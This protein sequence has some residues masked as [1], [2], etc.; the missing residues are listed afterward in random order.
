MPGSDFGF[1]GQ[2]YDAPNPYQDAQRLINWYLE[3]SSSGKPKMPTTLLG[4]PGLNPILQLKTGA[5]RG[6]WVLP[7]NEKAVVVSSDTVYLVT[8][9]VPAT[10]NSIAEFATRIIGTLST[11][12]GQVRMRDN[13]AGGYVSI[14]DGTST[15][16]YFRINGASTTTI[17]ATPTSGSATLPYSGT[18]NSALIVGSVLSG[19]GIAA[20]ATI[21]SINISA[22]SITMSAPATSS[23]G[24]TTVTVTLAEFGT[25]PLEAPASH[26]AFIDGWLIINRVG[27]QRFATSAPVPYT[28][29]FDPLF[30]ALKDSQSDNLQGLHELNRELWLIGERS[31]EIWFTAPAANFGFQRVPGASP[32][33]GTSAPQTITKAGDSLVWLGRTSEGE[34]IA[35]QTQQYSWKR[36]SQHGVEH[37][38]SKYALISDAF[39]FAYEEEGHLFVMFT[40]PTADKTWVWDSNSTWHERAKFNDDTGTFHRHRS[41]CFMNLQNLRLVGD[42]QTGQLHQ[43]SRN[44]FTDAGEPIV[45]VRRCP[46]VWSAEDR[47]KN[48]SS[49]IQIDFSP[50]VGLQN[51]QGSDPRLM[52]RWSND[53]GANF[54]VEVW[55]RVGKAGQT[56]NRAIK[57]RLGSYFDRIY[58]VRYSEPTNRDIVGATI[59]QIPNQGGQI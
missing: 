24:A 9:T 17:T 48:F 50:G 46:H 42:Y 57:R 49:A 5:V 34:N 58:E 53:A 55:L 22:N 11:N 40:F 39:S 13:G 7:G 37:Q 29:I 35:I 36:I 4:T 18:L 44:F 19:T 59:Y 3:M 38:I 10:Q 31:S 45:A 54:P 41:N 25:I 20:G 47:K 12:S 26:I 33:I 52:L 32:P 14:V 23:P 15:L 1:V 51:G 56:K 8:T 30:F 28:M 2:A 43:M 27:S 21:Q 6:S 16:S